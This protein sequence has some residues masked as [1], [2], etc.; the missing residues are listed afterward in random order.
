MLWT[1]ENV[2]D[3]PDFSSDV[4]TQAMLISTQHLLPPQ[5]ALFAQVP[6]LDG[7]HGDEDTEMDVE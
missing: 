2:E 4:L 6:Q 1:A 3:I 5:P 7:A